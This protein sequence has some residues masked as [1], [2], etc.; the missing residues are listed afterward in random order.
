MENTSHEDRFI[1]S[2]LLSACKQCMLRK[3]LLKKMKYVL[4]SSQDFL[5]LVIH[6]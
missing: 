1:S 6:I 3:D 2:V 4:Y 5:S